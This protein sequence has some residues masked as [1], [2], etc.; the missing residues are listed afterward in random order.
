MTTH[1]IHHTEGFQIIG[2]E[3]ARDRRLSGLARGIMLLVLS[4][5]DSWTAS[6]EWIVG[7]VREG[8][9]AVQRALHE[10]EAAGYRKVTRTQGAGG[11]W[12]TT[13]DWYASPIAVE[14]P[15]DE[16]PTAG[17]PSVGDPAPIQKNY[18]EELSEE[19]A[20]SDPQEHSVPSEPLA[21]PAKRQGP[22]QR[23]A[24]AV[25]GAWAAGAKATEQRPTASQRSRFA[26]A[27]HALASEIGLDALPPEQW[28]RMIDTAYVLGSRMEFHLLDAWAGGG[29]RP[30]RLPEHCRYR[31]GSRGSIGES[32][33]LNTDQPRAEWE[34]AA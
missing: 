3:L 22:P 33:R 10:L 24:G 16:Q 17:N 19:A 23:T 21:A 14:S 28:L 15:T 1:R 27:A 6:I 8:R 26:R 31:I 11:H 7:E 18:P 34:A 13:I 9:M 29:G 32:P 12:A 20:P 4:H 30:P 5:N 25:V 2:N